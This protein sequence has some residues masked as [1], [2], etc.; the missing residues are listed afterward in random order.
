MYKRKENYFKMI[1]QTPK[2]SIIVPIYNAAEYLSRSIQCLINQTLDDIEIILVDDG[3]TDESYQIC[4]R[5]QS[6]DKRIKLFHKTNEGQGIARNYGIEHASGEFVGF[7]DSDDTVDVNMFKELYEKAQSCE[8]DMVYSFM[9]NEIMSKDIWFENFIADTKEY[10]VEVIN[11]I[12]GSLPIE[13]EDSIL[14]MSVW[15]SIFRRELINSRNIRFIS[16]RK[17]NS[18]DM[19]FNFDFLINCNKVAFVD[20]AFYKYCHDNSNSFSVTYN[21]K[22][23]I[24][25]KNLY[26]ELKKRL[27]MYNLNDD[28]QLLR[29]QRRFLANVR[30]ILME[31]AR[32][33][34]KN[35][36][37]HVL[38][39]IKEILN[40]ELLKSL[41]NDYPI[42]KLP[43][44]QKVY[45]KMMRKK[46]VYS[47]V[48]LAKL[49]M[50][51]L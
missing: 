2:V 35:N 16:E 44:K 24:M 19:L 13:Q 6:K 40:D 21:D 17:V 51:F 11:Q 22:R 28:Y 29:I 50:K 20:K 8:A 25:F 23:F 26:N 46:K 34:N 18:E 48:I 30:V 4:E 49:K 45:F 47:L 42:D 43:F 15:R 10:R 36:R 14:G 9:E 12:I 38:E 5:Y 33:I 39:S 37:L 7:M 1:N 31:K 3:S 32:W 27:D 41:L